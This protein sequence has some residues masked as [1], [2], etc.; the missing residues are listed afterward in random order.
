[1]QASSDSRDFLQLAGQL[2]NQIWKEGYRYAKAGIMLTEICREDQ[3]Q[4]SLLEPP[5]DT[6]SS[7]RLM[8]A[9]DKI[10]QTT[11]GKIRFGSQRE[12]QDWFMNQT[13]LSPSYTTRWEDL[14]VAK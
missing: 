3:L 13:R 2:F 8:Q 4:L 10:N 7:D 14:P 11:S 9:I 6:L 5:K 1:M 12:Q